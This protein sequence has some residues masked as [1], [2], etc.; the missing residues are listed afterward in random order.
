MTEEVEFRGLF[1]TSPSM[2]LVPGRWY[3]GFVCLTCSHRF[4]V[5]DDPNETGGT[6]VG[7]R[8]GFIVACPGCSATHSY[9]ADRMVS[10][11]AATAQPAAPVG[12]VELG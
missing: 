5:M 10:F 8:G 12:N 11:Q 7:G 2:N 9:A 3:L 1:R 4:G 6:K